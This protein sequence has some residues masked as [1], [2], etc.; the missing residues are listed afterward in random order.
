MI[1][2]HKPLVRSWVHLPKNLKSRSFS[3][4]FSSLLCYF[5]GVS[6]QKNQIVQCY[7]PIKQSLFV[8]C[9]LTSSLSCLLLAA[10][11]SFFLAICSLLQW[12][13]RDRFFFW[14]GGGGRS[15]AIPILHQINFPKALGIRF[16]SWHTIL[17]GTLIKT[18]N[19]LSGNKISGCKKQLIL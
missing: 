8:F 13:I 4:L 10:V 6:L 11:L 19:P 3:M 5:H 2:K 1:A 14:G 15:C 12:V 17:G 9:F 16:S 18:T 7:F